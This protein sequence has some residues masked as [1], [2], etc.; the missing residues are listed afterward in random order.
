MPL[1]VVDPALT[2]TVS[3]ALLASRERGRK[4]LC[5]A[6]EEGVK[7][8]KGFGSTT[9]A[10]TRFKDILKIP[11]LVR[12][13]IKWGGE[14]RPV[15]DA[16]QKCAAITED[17]GRVMLVPLKELQP[18]VK[19]YYTKVSKVER[20][21]LYEVSVET[22][23]AEDPRQCD[24]AISARVYRRILASTCLCVSGAVQTYLAGKSSLGTEWDSLWN[25]PRGCLRDEEAVGDVGK[26]RHRLPRCSASGP[27][28]QC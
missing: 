12:S 14:D 28:P 6:A 23:A 8:T 17:D 26:V 4:A 19:Y 3:S 13:I 10:S 24:S 2:D 7:G 9:A 16:L 1:S 18:F 5:D 15:P 11:P 22:T 20:V 25:L 27:D 21:R